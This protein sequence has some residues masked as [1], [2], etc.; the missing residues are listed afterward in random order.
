MTHSYVFIKIPHA[1]VIRAQFSS[2][3][4]KLVLVWLQFGQK[5]GAILG[6]KWEHFGRCL[7]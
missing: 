1:K 4:G 2:L 6:G 3:D 5:V 7:Q